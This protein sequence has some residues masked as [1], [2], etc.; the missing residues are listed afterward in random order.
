MQIT[1]V[2]EA[3]EL[4][5]K[6]TSY[7]ETLGIA[8]E[9]PKSI[10]AIAKLAGATDWNT[11]KAQL[12]VSQPRIEAS[13]SPPVEPNFDNED[14]P[15]LRISVVDYIIKDIQDRQ[16]Q[17]GLKI[18][19]YAQALDLAAKSANCFRFHATKYELE[20]AAQILF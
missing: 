16:R 5:N 6:L 2:A 14:C 11:L 10:E 12:E 9:Y 13:S 8:L 17:S 18:A 3:K 4:A 1:S 20:E 15:T 7:L 19:S